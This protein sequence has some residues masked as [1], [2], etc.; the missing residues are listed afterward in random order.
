MRE[1]YQHWGLAAERL[2]KRGPTAPEV[3][4]VHELAASRG[5]WAHALQRP[6][7]HYLPALPSQPF[8][9][10]SAFPAARTLEEA[11]PQILE[12]LKGLLSNGSTAAFQ[13]IAQAFTTLSDADKRANYDAGVDVKSTRRGGGSDSESE[14][15]EEHKQSLREEIERK[16]Y[17]ER[18]DFWPF[19]DPFINKRKRAE[20][21]AKQKARQQGQPQRSWHDDDD[22]D[23]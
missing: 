12:E 4:Q 2:H 5:V 21:K 14:E 22:D 19:G 13:R 3:R 8:W 1:V 18:Y 11:F 10:A 7:D 15:D 6:L 23:Y 16:Y 17:P 9:P 20:A